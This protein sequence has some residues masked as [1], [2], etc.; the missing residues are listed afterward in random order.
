MM[1]SKWLGSS[2]A[3]VHSRGSTGVGN[4]KLQV[5]GE[6]CCCSLTLGRAFVVSLIAAILNDV[7]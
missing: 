7:I 2:R 5:L 6:D 1:P 3:K 4:C